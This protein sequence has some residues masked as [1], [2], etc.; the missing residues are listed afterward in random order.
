MSIQPIQHGS[1]NG[2]QVRIFRGGRTITKFLAYKKH[3]GKKKALA[4]AAKI[5]KALEN[6]HP[7]IPSR[8]KKFHANRPNRNSTTGI[9]GIRAFI[10][11]R[12]KRRPV[13]QFNAQW[14]SGR[15]QRSSAVYG[16][17]GAL[18]QVLDARQNATGIIMPSAK[19]AW[20]IIKR[21]KG[22]R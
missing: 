6:L 5:E 15:L 12:P 13:L 19:K 10:L 16:I 7:V 3:G 2:Y 21:Q 8:K 11:K 14:N 4:L 1:S 17:L 18:Q 20:E 9:H 22:W